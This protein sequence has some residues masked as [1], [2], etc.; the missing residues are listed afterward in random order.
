MA[1]DKKKALQDRE[2]FL[3][4]FSEQYPPMNIKQ[5]KETLCNAKAEL[6]G[7]GGF[8][9]IYIVK[10]NLIANQ[11][12]RMHFVGSMDSSESSRLTLKNSKCK[13]TPVKDFIEFSRGNH[14]E[15]SVR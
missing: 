1:C 12:S 15:F 11:E 2:L 10:P 5:I 9:D 4:E 7:K 6:F 8:V 3:K 14:V 13:W